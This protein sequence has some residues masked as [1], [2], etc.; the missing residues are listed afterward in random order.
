MNAGAQETGRVEVETIVV[1]P[2]EVNCY[3]ASGDGRTAFVIDPGGDAERIRGALAARGWSPAAYLLT[4]GHI[5]HIA[6]LDAL[7]A[8]Q[9]A[10][11]VLSEADAGW[12]FAPRNTMPPFYCTAPAGPPAGLQRVRDGALREGAGLRLDVLATPGH[13]A[14]C[15]CFHVAAAGILFCGDTVF[16]GSV[17]RTDLPGGDPRV[18][19]ASLKRLATLPPSTVL[20]PGHGPRTTLEHELRTN[21]YMRAG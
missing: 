3:L 7:L 21:V 17:G 9:P 20:Y 1:G 4:H 5:D 12:A 13:T 2:F 18:L 14:G 11:V 6:A 8:R 16:A 10:P 19:A 15:V